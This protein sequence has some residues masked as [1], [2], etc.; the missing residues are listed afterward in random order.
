MN[1]RQ[2]ANRPAAGQRRVGECIYVGGHV[3][4]T[5]VHSLTSKE[6][7][8]RQAIIAAGGFDDPKMG[9]DT[10]VRLVRKDNGKRIEALFQWGNLRRQRRNTDPVLQADDVIEIESVPQVQARTIRD[11]AF[12]S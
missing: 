1:R 9:D 8:V 4:C 5:G 11:A 7:H 10:Q 2:H 3:S 6:I 12:H